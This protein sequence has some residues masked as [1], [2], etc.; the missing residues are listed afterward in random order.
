MLPFKVTVRPCKH[1][2]GSP[3]PI[4]PRD[5]FD[6]SGSL[7]LA[8]K[9]QFRHESLVKACLGHD[10]VP[11]LWVFLASASSMP[12]CPGS[13]TGDSAVNSAKWQKHHCSKPLSQ[14]AADIGP[15]KQVRLA[16]G[17]RLVTLLT[18]DAG[19]TL[20]IP[21]QVSIACFGLASFVLIVGQHMLSMPSSGFVHF[22]VSTGN[23]LCSHHQSIMAL[24]FVL[25]LHQM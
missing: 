21:Q 12:C 4:K 9:R 5:A 2:A 24:F 1:I 15:E 8:D 3:A 10:I 16:R 13:S 11:G 18:Q 7:L 19:N 22:S 17:V 25:R 6:A 20:S 23:A 14:F